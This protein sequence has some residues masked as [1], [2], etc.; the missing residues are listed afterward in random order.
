MQKSEI[1]QLLAKAALLDNR[2][3][4]AATVEAWHEIIG[5]IDYPDALAALTIHRRTSSDYLMPAHILGNLRA[6]R[7]ARAIE[8]NR[9][10]ALNP[11]KPQPRTPMP[12]WFRDAVANFGKAPE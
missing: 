4:D 12:Q 7:E 11:P 5:H 2:K 3:I 10:R 9:R 1:A 8:A 6:A